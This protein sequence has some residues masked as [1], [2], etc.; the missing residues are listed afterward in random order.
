MEQKL[1]DISDLEGC[2]VKNLLDSITEALIIESDIKSA[3]LYL[4]AVYERL[5]F[6]RVIFTD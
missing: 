3:T 5:G 2:S 4:D 6:E 1:Q